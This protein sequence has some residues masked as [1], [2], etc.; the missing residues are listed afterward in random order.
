ML[1]PVLDIWLIEAQ[2][3]GDFENALK[4]MRLSLAD[5]SDTQKIF[6][7]AS[8]KKLEAKEDISENQ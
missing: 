1:E 7:A 8:I 4:E 5:A 2:A 6:P 3:E